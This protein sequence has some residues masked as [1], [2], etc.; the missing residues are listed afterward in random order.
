MVSLKGQLRWFLAL[1]NSI[2]GFESVAPDAELDDGNFTLVYRKNC[3]LFNMLSLMIQAINGGK[4]VHDENV[5]YPL[6]TRVVDRNV[7]EKS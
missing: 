7:R 6:K 5:E 1:T 3:K 4:H 2:T